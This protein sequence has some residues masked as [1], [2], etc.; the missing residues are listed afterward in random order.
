MRAV[1]APIPESSLEEVELESGPIF[2][3]LDSSRPLMLDNPAKSQFS[4]VIV[5]ITAFV[6]LILFASFC[7]PKD[8]FVDQ[9]FFRIRRS[10]HSSTTS[11]YFFSFKKKSDATKIW[12]SVATVRSRA[13]VSHTDVLYAGA[14]VSFTSS[15]GSNKT[16]FP[17]T[18]HTLRYS[19]GH[20]HSD[21]IDLLA[22][23]TTQWSTANV[24]LH[25]NFGTEAIDGI[26]F[27]WSTDNPWNPQ[28]RH[29]FS[30]S[31]S[32]CL[33]IF[34]IVLLM[35]MRLRF[36]QAG[37]LVVFLL[38][39]VSSRSLSSDAVVFHLIEVIAIAVL[40]LFLFYIIAFIANKHRHFIAHIEFALIAMSCWFGLFSAWYSWK[41]QM[42]IV[43]GHDILMHMVLAAVT[44]SMIASM[45]FFAED[46]F[47]FKLYA[48]LL[49]LHLGTT[50][51]ACDV[52]KVFP[53]V[54]H[55]L[56]PKIT[57]YGMHLVIFSVMA[58][59]HQGVRM[60]QT[61]ANHLSDSPSDVFI[62][63]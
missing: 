16:D 26:L 43:H 47:T 52:V 50:L 4:D 39:V 48:T 46:V 10:E 18:R 24:R 1:H 59:Y 27:E 55:W 21:P 11:T 53:N 35:G 60:T 42:S 33:G 56:E 45:Y 30:L 3:I 22:L 25:I 44:G 58:Y 15:R 62:F 29:L 34:A 13:R 19:P 9:S 8:H 36:E 37:T 49:M 5:Y 32:A 63:E 28:I 41:S 6:I 54:E 2:T 7:A 23:D 57:F 14:N 51:L 20:H 38:F 40:R 12:L 61:D 31:F 17:T